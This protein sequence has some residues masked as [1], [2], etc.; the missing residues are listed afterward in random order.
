MKSPHKPSHDHVAAEAMQALRLA[1]LSDKD[2]TPPG[3]ASVWLSVRQCV[4]SC[5]SRAGKAGEHHEWLSCGREQRLVGM[6]K[7]A[8]LAT[9]SDYTLP[10]PCG[11]QNSL[12]LC[13]LLSLYL[14]FSLPPPASS[15]LLLLLTGAEESM[16]LISGGTVYVS[17]TKRNLELILLLLFPAGFSSS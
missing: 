8:A 15:T 13:F 7:Q 2:A 4:V 14:L 1:N 9:S 10:F 6:A 3:H 5:F 11:E 12:G 17:C 16:P